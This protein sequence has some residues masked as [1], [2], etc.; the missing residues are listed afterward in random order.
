M[1]VLAVINQKG[2]VGKTTT[3]LTLAAGLSLR[4]YSVLSVD[5]DAQGNLTYTTGAD[6]SGPTVLAVLTGEVLAA[7]A[8][9]HTGSGDIIPAS[10]GKSTGLKKPWSR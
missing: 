9:Q 4:G 2:G 10:R 3:A 7:D 8:I 1:K 5:L 6:T